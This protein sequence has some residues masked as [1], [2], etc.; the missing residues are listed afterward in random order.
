MTRLI[1]KEFAKTLTSTIKPGAASLPLGPAGLPSVPT[2]CTSHLVTIDSERNIVSMTES[3][4]CY[5]GSGIVVPD[6]GI[7]L[8]DTMHDFDPRPESTEFR[9]TMEDSDEQHEPHNHPQRRST[10]RDVRVSRR[11][12]ELSH[13]HSKLSSTFSTL[14]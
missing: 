5:F 2:S 7:I 10:I 8:N 11:A 3:V 12:Q 6:T 13:L 4:E 14:D 9:G 1:S